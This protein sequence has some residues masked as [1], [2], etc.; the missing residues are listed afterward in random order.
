MK[1][2]IH[3]TYKNHSGVVVSRFI[4]LGHIDVNK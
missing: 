3:V 4:G 1:A 2:T